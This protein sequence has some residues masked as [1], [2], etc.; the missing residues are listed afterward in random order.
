[1]Q[2]ILTV[3][4]NGPGIPEDDLPRIFQRFYR[5][6][7]KNVQET[8]GSGV[9]LYLTRQILERQKGTVFVKPGRNGGSKFVMTLPKE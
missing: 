1:M 3:T 8:E 5:G 4:D 2:V 9:G 7:Q 6:E